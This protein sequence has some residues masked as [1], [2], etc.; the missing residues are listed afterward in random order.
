MSEAVWTVAVVAV[1]LTVVLLA[2]VAR[3]R[4]AWKVAR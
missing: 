3:S 2:A 1:A 4:L